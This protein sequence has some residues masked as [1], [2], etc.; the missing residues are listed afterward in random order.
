MKRRGLD[1]PDA[2]RRNRN[3]DAEQGHYE[4]VPHAIK[5]P[6]LGVTPAGREK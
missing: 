1:L 6:F 2:G 4:E 5:G 3:G